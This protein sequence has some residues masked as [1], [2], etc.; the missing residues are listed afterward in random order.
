MGVPPAVGTLW[1]FELMSAA[2][3]FNTSL[4]EGSSL[5][6][7]AGRGT[8]TVLAGEHVPSVAGKNVKPIRAIVDVFGLVKKVDMADW[9]AC[10]ASGRS[11]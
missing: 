2:V 10:K 7:G 9:R 1:I 8:S 5:G 11:K 6:V 4:D 3:A